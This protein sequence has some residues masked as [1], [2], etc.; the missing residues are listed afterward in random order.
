MEKKNENY[1]V[2]IH[3][4]FLF[5]AKFKSDTTKC[6]YIYIKLKHLYHLQHNQSFSLDANDIADDFKVEVTTIYRSLKEL[7]EN[8]LL[9]KEGKNNYKLKD[10]KYKTPENKQFIMIYNNF[11]VDLFNKLRKLDKDTSK[12][13]QL[14]YYLTFKSGQH[15]MGYSKMESTESQNNICKALKL[16]NKTAKRLT[17]ALED[18][19]L[20][21]KEDNK[22]YT[23]NEFKEKPAPAK[24]NYERSYAPIV[25]KIGQSYNYEGEVKK[26]KVIDLGWYK[27]NDGKLEF[28]FIKDPKLGV[29]SEKCRISDGIPATPEEIEIREYVRKYGK[30]A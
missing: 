5:N 28:K 29:I 26:S 17:E 25:E 14:Y 3:P 2:K 21:C 19:N 27:S 9:K 20:I 10:E 16:H 30:V 1:Y 8:Q 13:I 23:R 6:I 7:V 18:I 4:E 22:T 11:F 12:A 15:A 24:T